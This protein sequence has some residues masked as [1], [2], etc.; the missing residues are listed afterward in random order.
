MNIV[1]VKYNGG[2]LGRNLGCERAPDKLVISGG[3]LFVDN[4]N[5]DKTMRVLENADGNIFLGGDHSITYGLFKGFAKKF[6]NAGLLVFD[7]HPDCYP[8]DFVNHENWVY[9]LIK[10]GI[11][12]KENIVFVGL[13]AIDK[14]EEKFLNDKK[15]KCFYMDQFFNSEEEV[16]DSIMEI[17]RDFGSV[18]L[19]IDIDVLDPAFAPGTGYLEPGGMSTLQLFY[20]LKRMRNLRNLKR[21]DLVEINPN[22]DNNDVTVKIGKKIIEIFT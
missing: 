22:K 18:Y 21:V 19:S 10:E 11:L 1:K 16:C 20:F 12:K 6:T 7:A 2:C 8:E 15:I 3:D 17:A 13:R 14:E 4:C 5:V 9:H